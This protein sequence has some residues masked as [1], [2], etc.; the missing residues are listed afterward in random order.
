MVTHEQACVFLLCTDHWSVQPE[1]EARCALYGVP[2][3]TSYSASVSGWALLTPHLSPITLHS[4]I[5]CTPS[6]CTSPSHV[7]EIYSSEQLKSLLT[8]E[9][10]V[11]YVIVNLRMVADLLQPLVVVPPSLY[12]LTTYFLLNDTL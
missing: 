9:V 4:C 7:Q 12:C 3:H 10:C 6:P 1:N 8:S 2:A 11:L 5:L